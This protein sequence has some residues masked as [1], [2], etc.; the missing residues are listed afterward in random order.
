MSREL[1]TL[2]NPEK[3]LQRFQEKKWFLNPMHGSQVTKIS[4]IQR[5]SCNYYLYMFTKISYLKGHSYCDI[6]FRK[7][8]QKSL[9]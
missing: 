5:Y 8:F 3:D 7:I 6:K 9:V 2:V 1:L 4:A